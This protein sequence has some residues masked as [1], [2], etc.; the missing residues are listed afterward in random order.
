M[1]KIKY[2]LETELEKNNRLETERKLNI[3]DHE[4]SK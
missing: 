4:K 2:K 1:K 3:K